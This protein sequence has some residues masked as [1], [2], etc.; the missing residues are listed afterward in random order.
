MARNMSP[1]GTTPH[2]L[3]LLFAQPA[4]YRGLVWRDQGLWVAFA[5]RHRVHQPAKA[6]GLV[7][8]GLCG[9]GALPSCRGRRRRHIWAMASSLAVSATRR[10]PAA[11]TARAAARERAVVARNVWAGSLVTGC[12]LPPGC[13][14]PPFEVQ[15]MLV[16]MAEHGTAVRVNAG[17]QS[18]RQG[19]RL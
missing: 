16:S 3:K 7:S 9:G 5:V 15:S 13:A 4:G 6:G 18:Q 12:A 14:R 2:C 1:R 11:S 19:V 17:R 10:Q 8:R